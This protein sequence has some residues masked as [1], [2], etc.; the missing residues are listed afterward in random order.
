M[1]MWVWSLASRSGLRIQ[2]GHKLWLRPQMGLRSRAAVAGASAS[3]CSSDWT[4][5]LGTSLCCRCA[6]PQKKRKKEKRK[7]LILRELSAACPHKK[8]KVK[9]INPGKIYGCP[10]TPSSK[11]AEAVS[12]FLPLL[13]CPQR[14]AL[15]GTGY[16]DEWMTG[17]WLWWEAADIE[18]GRW[19][20][21]DWFFQIKCLSLFLFFIEVQL[22]TMCSFQ[23]YRKGDSVICCRDRCIFFFRS[24]SI[25]Y[26]KMPKIVPWAIQ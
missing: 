14:Q 15:P 21:H 19:M 1:R 8:I 22:F 3:N 5:N 11:R 2:H 25:S 18:G 24:F 7:R 4:P 23:V 9:K 12:S 26:D 10:P 13:S 6:P 16:P 17:S 20:E